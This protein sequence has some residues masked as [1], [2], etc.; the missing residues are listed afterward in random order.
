MTQRAW[1]WSKAAAA[2][3]VIGAAIVIM[4]CVFGAGRGTGQAGETLQRHGTQLADLEDR[5][6]NVEGCV[7]EM[8]TD[9]RWLRADREAERQ[10]EASP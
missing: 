4:S 9:V 8:A 1:N 10:R 6:R 7:H 2:A 5:M 3:S